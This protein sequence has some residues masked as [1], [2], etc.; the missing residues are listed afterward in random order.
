MNP[1]TAQLGFE[2]FE[3]DP[4]RF[5][6]RCKGETV[7]VEPQVFNLLMYLVNHRDRVVA[8][9]EIFNELWGHHF[10][11][12]AALATQIKA[13]RRA[14]G[15]SGAEQRIIKTARGRGYRFVA[16]IEVKGGSQGEAQGQQAELSLPGVSAGNLGSPRTPLFGR[17]EDVRRC[18]KM[19]A[20]HRMVTVLGIG[21]TGKT[22]LAKAVG[23][24]L[25]PEFPEGVWFVDLIPVTNGAGIDYAIA[26]ALGLR[27]GSGDARRQLAENLCDRSMLL[28]LDNCEHIEDEV[29]AAMDCLLEFTRAP[30][31]LMT[32]RDPVDLADEYRFFLEPFAVDGAAGAAAAVQFFVATAK[33]QGGVVAADDRHAIERLCRQLDGLP[34]AIE[35]AAS[36]LHYLSLD[37]LSQRL[38]RRFELLSGRQRRDNRRQNSLRTVLEDTWTLLTPQERQM[39][40][41]LAVFP[42]GF[43]MPDAEALLKTS[44]QPDVPFA[45]SRF[46]ELSLVCR[47]TGTSAGWQLLE[48]VKMFA[49]AQSDVKT[50]RQNAGH[51]G[52]WCLRCVGNNVLRH[53][54]DFTAA[55]W[56]IAH[57]DDIVAAQDFFHQEVDHQAVTTLCS[58]L[59]LTMQ[60]D[61]GVRAREQLDR[62]EHYLKFTEDL[63]LRSQ[64]HAIAAVC[65]M[66]LPD[67]EVFTRHAAAG[68]EAA[69]GLGDEKEIAS[70]LILM[71]VRTSFADP[72]LALQQLDKAVLLAAAHAEQE[73]VDGANTFRAWRLVVEGKDQEAGGY[74]REIAERQ[75][76]TGFNNLT[77]NAVCAL[78]VCLMLEEPDE[79]LAWTERLSRKE[80]AHLLWSAQLLMACIFAMHNRIDDSVQ[81]VR[82]VRS[83]LHQAGCD[84]LPDILIPAALLARAHGDE[85]RAADFL[86]CV[87]AMRQ[88]LQSFHMTAAY[89]RARRMISIE[90]VRADINRERIAAALDT[91][92]DPG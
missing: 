32:S 64:L 36:Q 71:S 30:K 28:I 89:Q 59:S 27:L 74:A 54:H 85:T 77:F 14:L 33:R 26:N 25:A 86:G 39:I 8:K 51:H 19:I 38:D 2:D 63:Y 56:A 92:L 80:D 76:E 20:R 83:R 48:S 13:L 11:S 34:L 15:D 22:T 55:R 18:S 88:P 65:G 45:I 87:K 5:E 84:S 73:L 12:D 58:A 9:D 57:Y 53:R 82:E 61:E 78:I 49:L 72:P 68:L 37:E 42:A 1:L 23:R 50:R 40:A 79:A 43:T 17:D 66:I 31:F 81:L 35:L 24:H 91:V 6:L 44:A 69:E 7:A 67:L 3:I 75:F 16:S 62:V 4:A 46:V 52:A 60:L 21:G 10:V 41:L 29:A 70:Q 47:T 90:G